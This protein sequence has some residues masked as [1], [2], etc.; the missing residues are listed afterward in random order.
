[1]NASARGVWLAKLS[2]GTALLAWLIA[3]TD[4]GNLWS[5]LRS[6]D[7]LWL[8]PVLILPHFGVLLSSSKWQI[9]LHARGGRASLAVLFQLYMIGTFFN[10]FLPSMV[11]G[12]VVRVYQLSRAG[13]ESSVVV[14]STFLER[15][16]GLVALVSILPFAALQPDLLQA[17]PGLW[18]IIG[19]TAFILA[20]ACIVLFTGVGA[21]AAERSAS[22][23]GLLPRIRRVLVRSRHQIQTYRGHPGALITSY[24][25]SIAFYLLAGLTV[26]CATNAVRGSADLWTLVCVTPLVLLI[27]LIPV[28]VNGLGVLEAGYTWVLTSLGMTVSEALSVALLLRCRILITAGIGGLMFL[29]YRRAVPPASSAEVP[30]GEPRIP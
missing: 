13:C 26:W 16:L 1:M 29:A 15:F 4:L 27:G 25:I 30:V 8:V 18:P 9:L 22:A 21:P 5:V 17:L 6:V 20:C 3:R 7:L 19:V 2:L 24:A 14:A 12:D 28:S 10:S 23:A 11:G